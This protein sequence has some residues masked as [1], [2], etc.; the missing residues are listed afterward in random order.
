MSEVRHPTR[1]SVICFHIERFML[2]RGQ[3]LIGFS[4]EVAIHY[5]RLTPVHAQTVPLKQANIGN[6]VDKFFKQQESNTKLLQRW[7]DGTT[8]IPI[9]VEEALIDALPEPY[10]SRCIHDL[11]IRMGV[12]PIRI[13]APNSLSELADVIREGAEALAA[14]APLMEDGVI[15]GNDAEQAQNAAKE[16]LEAGAAHLQRAFHIC[17]KA[18]VKLDDSILGALL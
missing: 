8:K 10:H 4:G 13:Q 9:E 18:G 5:H 14:E 15:D 2:E 11:S 6:D 3:S 1:Q 7:I 16:H 17:K 12:L